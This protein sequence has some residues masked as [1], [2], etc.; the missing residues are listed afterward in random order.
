MRKFE[1]TEDQIKKLAS[2]TIGRD[3]YIHDWFPQAFEPDWEEVLLRNFMISPGFSSKPPWHWFLHD[4][5]SMSA[6]P[7]LMIKNPISEYK[8]NYKIEDG[9]IWRRKA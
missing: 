7:F 2:S 9:K 6:C 4:V 5:G 8:D 1:I 3:V